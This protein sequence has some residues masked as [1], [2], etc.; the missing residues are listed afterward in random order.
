MYSAIR[1]FLFPFATYAIFY[2]N[3]RIDP[4]DLKPDLAWHNGDFESSLFLTQVLTS[5]AGYAFAWIACTM[6]FNII[7]FAL[8]LLLSTPIS[9]LVWHFLADK[10]D[11]ADTARVAFIT[12]EQDD[13]YK[14]IATGVWGAIYLGQLVGIAYYLCTKT[15][16]I[17]S[18][19]KDMFIT[20]HYDAVFLEQQLTLNR[21]VRKY[22]R[23]A[24][25]SAPERMAS[26]RKPRYVF[27]CSTMY[28]ENVTEMR[29]MLKSIKGVSQW[30]NKQSMSK[31]D[32][33]DKFESHIFF[34]GAINGDQL[35][36]YGLQL[37][38]LVAECLDIQSNEG[39]W[40]K[41]PYGYA[42][43]WYIGKH[44][45]RRYRMR[46]TVHFKDNLKVKNKKRWSQVMYMNYVINHRIMSEDLSKDNTFILT[47]DADIDFTADS[48]VVLLDNLASNQQVGAV[49]AR[50]HP[51]GFGPMYW[52]QI[53]DYA[54]GHWFQKPAEHLF[55]SVLCC[56]GCFSVFRCRA[57]D[58]VLEEYSSEVN[59]AMDF[60][61][62]DMGEDRWLCTLMIRKGWRLDYC[63]I[64]K[65]KTYCPESFNEF[66]K[67]RRRWIPS[68]VANLALLISE[69]GNI[70][71]NN[72]SISILFILFQAVMAFSTIISPATVILIIASGLQ[73]AYKISDEAVLAIIILLLVLSTAY[74]M[75]C[76]YTSQKTQLDVA[77]LL[78]FL[79]VI[80][81]SVVVAGIVKELILDFFPL[82]NSS[83]NM[84]GSS[85]CADES[86]PDCDDN[87]DFAANMTSSSDTY[88][89]MLTSLSPTT[90]YI[91]LFG[92]LFTLAALLHYGEWSCLIHCVWYLLLLPSG[93][94]F[95]L[96][97]SSANLD[98]QSWGTR[99]AA[100]K[101][102]EGVTALIMKWTKK[103]VA[104]VSKLWKR[105]RKRGKKVEIEEPVTLLPDTP[106][107]KEEEE[108]EEEVKQKG[109]NHYRNKIKVG[110]R[111][112]NE[113][114]NHIIG[115][116]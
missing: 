31:G 80:I 12:T 90:W 75:I 91:A 114:H 79:F 7:G 103:L 61:T 14:H 74:G 67:Q 8:P 81:M 95:L 94:L 38:S 116:S 106:K 49:C 56:P 52:Y 105:C 93:Y 70:T 17:L 71:K 92:T 22:N 16:L 6:T 111:C 48:A 83:D 89:D 86:D 46:F 60:L 11:I 99:E 21:Q 25:E 66:Y 115:H 36:Y 88:V 102:D 68:T 109:K 32:K 62:K 41:T 97:Y 65:D 64:S 104:L 10:I 112:K 107:D 39:E 53:F 87:L 85:M 69:A 47:T 4:W 82:G 63:A 96:I 28:R 34:D 55:G 77:K 44:K 110:R 19:D 2:L 5:F 73:G 45:Q 51:K 43:T 9:I 33:A 37:V 40:L 27:I 13:I 18:Q 23:L 3:V 59:G 113:I 98:S 26:V 101:S 29:Q 54:V 1:I 108:K 76:L 72:S 35:T 84:E 20:P 15:N 24:L 100:S 57:L 42:M 58:E 78:T 50:T 30:H